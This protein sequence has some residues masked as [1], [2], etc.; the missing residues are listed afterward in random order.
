VKQY[1]HFLA[2]SAFLFLAGLFL[3]LKNLAVFGPWGEAAWGGLF[4]L[5]GLGFLIWFVFDSSRWWRVIPG[6]MLASIGVEILLA[7]R[8]VALGDWRGALVMFGLALGFWTVLIVQRDHWWA[9]MPA[10]ILTVLG[11]LTGLQA[12][13]GELAWL[14]LFF[15]GLGLVFLLLYLVRFGQTDMHWAGVPAAA[16]LLLGLVTL[17]STLAVTG[18]IAQWW[19]ILLVV[20]GLGLAIGSLLSKPATSPSPP[21]ENLEAI[22]QQVEVF[23]KQPRPVGAGAGCD[24]YDDENEKEDQSAP[25]AAA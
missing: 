5:A 12:R 24:E 1:Y 13:L 9:A 20:G 16:L 19:P 2:W 8:G 6:F 18:V 21:A 14:T 7:W 17:V 4:A 15:L 22:L 11:A 23:S 3:L 10:G 25:A